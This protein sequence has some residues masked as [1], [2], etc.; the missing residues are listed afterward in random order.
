MTPSPFS[1]IPEILDEIRAGRLIILVDD[2]D[3]ENEGD[4]VCA[5]EKVTPELV[6]FMVT[7]GRGTLC[8]TLTPARCEQLQ[9]H[10]QSPQNTTRL[11]TAFT[12]TIDAHPRYGVSTGVSASDRATTILAAIDPR[13]TPADLLRP[14]HVNP[15]TARDGG[16]LVRAGQTEGS[17][18]L[19]R[20]AGCNPSGVLIEI[21]NA[22]G[23]MARVPQL[24]EFAQ[25]FGLKMCTIAS[26]I[27]YRMQRESLV[28]R[29]AEVDI[30]TRYG[31]FR[32]YAY[33]AP[34]DSEPH[35][36]LTVG[37]VG[38]SP[39]GA[40][41]DRAAPDDPVLVRVH[42]ECITGDVFGSM[43]CE[44]G[45]Q[46]DVAL[47][48]LQQAGRGVLVYLRQEGRGIGLLNKLRAYR[49][50]DDGLDTVEANEKLGLP[51]DKR[52]YGIGA[53]ILRDL[54]VRRIRI[55][56]NNPKKISRLEI[57]GLEV[58]E[59]RP[60]EIEPNDVNRRYLQTKRAKLGHTLK[61]V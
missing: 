37:D 51:A 27:E 46:L 44:C 39:D 42:S 29:V 3:R 23:T 48:V 26:L 32:L 5:A 49:L 16:V 12:V 53:Q 34:T 43:R 18:D 17:V 28:Q 57:F 24:A 50:Q 2:E 7:H 25:R 60:I 10:P 20:L 31:P 38:R 47:R 15:L 9:L 61:D 8:L 1:P 6:N 52:D 22:D 54:G 56:T 55:L 19:A 58:V 45:E 30:Q 4:L 41:P 35:L 14:G 13:C 59:Q 33:R 40:A 21:L 36:A 11:G